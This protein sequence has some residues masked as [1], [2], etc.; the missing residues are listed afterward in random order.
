MWKLLEVVFLKRWM[1]SDWQILSFS[2]KCVLC[3][4]TIPRSGSLNS[5]SSF[6]ILGAVHLS[7]YWV[8]NTLT[9]CAGIEWF[10]EFDMRLWKYETVCYIK[11]IIYKNQE[12][13]YF[14]Y[15]NNSVYCVCIVFTAN[16]QKSRN[17]VETIKQMY[18]YY[19]HEQAL[20]IV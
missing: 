3:N 8:Q 2:R 13:C 14:S 9:G 4:F 7:S 10:G 18:N 16:K 20:K 12:K 6:R 1:V 11:L 5:I 17:N 19:K 15:C